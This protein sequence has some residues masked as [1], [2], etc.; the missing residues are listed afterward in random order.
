[1][2]L[3]T[4]LTPILAVIVFSWNIGNVSSQNSA[5]G[6]MAGVIRDKANDKA[7]L[8]ATVAIVDSQRRN[9]SVTTDTN[10]RYSFP[11][12]APGTYQ[13][14]A[15]YGRGF[16]RV[17]N[18][19]VEAGRTT[20]INRSIL[21]KGEED[22]VVIGDKRLLEEDR[23]RI[24]T[25]IDREAMERLPIP[26]S[27]FEGLLDQAATTIFDGEGFSSGGTTSLE[28]RYFVDGQDT[29]SLGDARV[30]SPISMELLQQVDVVSGGYAAE[31]GRATGAIVNVETRTGT[32]V[33]HGTIFS[34]F[35]NAFLQKRSAR[36]PLES[37]I[38]VETNQA[39]DLTLGVTLGGPI[40][41]DKL[42]FFVGLVPRLIATDTDR[43][44][45]RQTD[46][47][48]TL[49]DGSLSACEPRDATDPSLGF[50]YED[51][52]A[53]VDQN[54]IRIYDELDRKT[55]R[56]QA[57]EYQFV[58]KLNLR[59]DNNHAGQVTFS[60][61]PF[62]RQNVGVLGE[63]QAVSRNIQVLTTDVSGRWR[64][65]FN[66]AKTLLEAQFGV[67]RSTFTSGSI[68]ENADHIP[69]ERLIFGNFGDWAAG[70][71]STDPSQQRESRATV[72]GC[73]DSLDATNDPY[74]LLENCPD[75]GIGY[76]VG[77]IGFLADEEEQRTSGKLS[78]LQRVKALG[79]HQFKAGID[80][81]SGF[82]NKKRL[83][84]GDMYFTN[85]QGGRN[86]IEVFRYVA[87]APE[88]ANPEDFPD[89][90]GR[91][92]SM[93][94]SVACNYTPPGDV[95]GQT[96]NLAGYL[97]D[98]WQPIPKLTINAG[99]RYEEQRLRNAEHLQGTTAVGTGEAL[100]K[101]AMVLKDM[102][103]PRLGLAY[104]WTGQGKSKLY[105]SWGRYY[106]SIPM[107]INDRS[108]GG[109]SWMRSTY[110][111]GTL[112]Q[113]GPSDPSL[114]GPSATPSGA[115]CVASGASPAFGD[116][117]TGAGVLVATGVEAQYLDET[118]LG[119]DYEIAEDLS[120]GVNVQS[121]RIGRVLE[122]LSTNNADTYVLANPGSWPAKEE[123]KLL[124]A[125]EAEDDPA[126]KA[127]LNTALRQFRGIRN[128]DAPR[129][130]YNAVTVTAA[131]RFSR[132]IGVKA[133]YTYSSTQ[134]NYQ[135]LFSSDN[136]QVDPNIT[137][138]FDLPE[139]MANRD[140]PLPQ[141]RP[142]L[143]KFDGYYSYDLSEKSAI[144]TGLSF[145][146]ISGAPVNVTGAHYLYG[147]DETMR[148]PRGS[149]GRVDF[150]VNASAKIGFL[151]KL[152]RGMRLEGFI[153]VFNVNAFSFFGGQGTA[154]VEE[155]Y[156]RS[157]V[158]PVV[159]GSYEDLVFLKQFDVETGAETGTP[160]ERNRNFGNARE[161]FAAP[162]ARLTARLSF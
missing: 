62:S 63:I 109:E 68:D 51:G 110:D 71:N 150:D 108:F 124:D 97:Q 89:Q 81:E 25:S 158:N 26:G 93:S 111:S 98:S 112:E 72:L 75:T 92:Q 139:L 1:M 5:T 156:T 2:Q 104:D 6:S 16:V 143:F 101:N 159:G 160:V 54:G 8:A 125:I 115:G 39:Y 144:S 61:T 94:D 69:H 161:L 32:N 40:I 87:L 113:C 103:A 59:L 77:G 18:V 9:Y 136:G 122:D 102:W 121:R 83:I 82:L 37:W 35:T 47:R 91:G 22:I 80:A 17:A 56:S 13:F 141:D 45:K 142:H 95:R 27:S 30:G 100:G 138:L 137:S 107:D 34:Q 133:S 38:D 117:L 21:V 19:R 151:R 74:R 46:C 23:N 53:D 64:S 49:D 129:R 106:E 88:G 42:W 131:K 145:R 155:R 147:R 162:S 135:G 127:R 90:C 120:V 50:L 28:S 152:G 134:G 10:G 154:A 148:L 153:D 41:K 11:R 84:S 4:I 99:L 85:E 3:R 20:T 52:I 12:L 140:G 132:A 55:L 96:L 86:R 157:N 14:L 7:L 24:V 29:T 146:A 79:N 44:T 78:V 57:T 118:M 65:K 114:G 15:L 58:S 70:T 33:F 48:K 60:G 73:Q 67:H 43:I 66:D 123:E 128:F 130:D 116:T 76:S 36:A 119:I 126:A 31:H 105:G 149:M